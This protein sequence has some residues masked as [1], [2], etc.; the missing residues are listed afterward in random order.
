MAE[1]SK[2]LILGSG[3]A[4][5]HLAS[6]LEAMG[7]TGRE[8]EVTLVGREPHCTLTP[9][10]VDVLTGVLAPDRATK[11]VA[12]MLRSTEFVRGE[13]ESVVLSSQR[14]AVRTREGR[15]VLPYDHLVLALGGMADNRSLPGQERAYTFWSMSDAVMLRQRV[16]DELQGDHAPHFVVVGG[17]LLGVELAGELAGMLEPYMGGRYAPTLTLVTATDR[18]LPGQ[19]DVMADRAMDILIQR[20]VNIVL[21]GQAEAIDEKS[22]RLVG[23]MT[24]PADVVVLAMGVRPNPLVTELPVPHDRLGRVMVHPT[25]Q[26]VARTTLW[27]LG[28]CAAV[29]GPDGLAPSLAQHAVRQADLLAHNLAACVRGGS[30]R[31]YDYQTLGVMASLGPREAVAEIQGW[32]VWGEGVWW[33]RRAYYSWALPSTRTRLGLMA[34]WASDA[35]RQP[36]KLQ[37]PR[38]LE[39]VAPPAMIPGIIPGRMT[40]TWVATPPPGSNKPVQ[41]EPGYAS[42]VE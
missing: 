37:L 19:G 23:G 9:L 2:V 26:S 30:L 8:L 5:L 17:G 18:L 11:P 36:F 29:P 7:L 34:E 25:L 41:Q 22:L 32:T 1:A 20:G 31:T 27:A 10:L 33:A 35:L 13:V 42:D 14:V 38:L 4:G 16:L 39:G 21:Q 12:S 24:L 6:Q 40:V 28:D 15:V 3:F